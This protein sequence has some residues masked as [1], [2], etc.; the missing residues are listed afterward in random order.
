M[1][2][3][4]DE[5]RADLAKRIEARANGIVLSTAKTMGQA[6]AF[7][8]MKTALRD[9]AEQIRDGSFFEVHHD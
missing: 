7:H 9:L 8:D 4:T 1:T 2:P 5:Q 6:F 3:Y